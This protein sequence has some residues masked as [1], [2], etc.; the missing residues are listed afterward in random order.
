MATARRYR[1]A[2]N[3][4]GSE[5]IVDVRK[6]LGHSHME[7]PAPAWLSIGEPLFHKVIGSMD[8]GL[9]YGRAYE[10]YGNES[11]GKSL[12][13]GKIV[14]WGQKIDGAAAFWMDLENSYDKRWL[15]RLGVDTD[16]VA[17]IQPYLDEKANLT[18]SEV[19]FKEAEEVCRR[20]SLAYRKANQ[21]PVI[22]GVIDSVAAV[23]PREEF[24]AGFADQNMRTRL[25]PSTFFGQAIK[26]WNHLIT[27]YNV[28][29]I[30]INQVRMNPNAI[31]KNPE[32][33]SGGNTKNFYFQSRVCI[34]KKAY[35]ISKGERIG[36]QGFLRNVKNKIG[37]NSRDGVIIGA[38]L[39]F[40]GQPDEFLDAKELKKEIKKQRK[41]YKRG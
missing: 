21:T 18:P 1:R 7:P 15:S 22:V 27:Q 6:Y 3:K 11:H 26:R 12:L 41:S 33:T 31:F 2:V 10:L 35:V 16:G 30:C 13:A 14:S 36:V 20:L 24:A 34:E 29:L 9:A 17:L 28:L 4:T 40:G 25:S 19:L 38:K 23:M 37:S 5:I 32:Y 39:F 8:R